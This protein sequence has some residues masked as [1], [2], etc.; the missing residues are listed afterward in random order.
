MG[1]G[2]PNKV[3]LVLGA[4]MGARHFLWVLLVAAK[5]SSI[6]FSGCTSLGRLIP[7]GR[8]TPGSLS[9]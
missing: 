2:N 4:L 8:S 7:W 3:G 9:F 6:S 1:T 5:P